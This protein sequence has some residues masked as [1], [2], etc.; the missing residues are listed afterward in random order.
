MSVRE[1]LIVLAHSQLCER[2]RE[3][4]LSEPNTVFRGRALTD[5]EKARLSGL[6]AS[7]FGSAERLAEASGCDL[8]DLN[9]YYDHPVARLRHF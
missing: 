3:R 2:C 9:Q 5:E 1:A 7:D 8:A 4:L 6:S